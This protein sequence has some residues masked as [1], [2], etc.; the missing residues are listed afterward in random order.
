MLTPVAVNVV[1]VDDDVAEIDPD[2]PIDA[3]I[4]RIA[5]A[6]LGHPALPLDRASHRIDDAEEFDE[7][8]VAG[9]VD[10]AAVVLGDGRVDQPGARRFEAP[11]RAF[12]VG[13]DQP[14]ITRHI[15]REDRRQS[16]FDASVPCRV[17]DASTVPGDPTRNRR[18][19]GLSVQRPSARHLRANIEA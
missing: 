2:A 3:G 12:L 7:Q 18:R 1:I 9:G 13:A 14:R 19:A 10:G 6:T 8:P 16:T 4:R 17:H 5:G 15:G 11:H